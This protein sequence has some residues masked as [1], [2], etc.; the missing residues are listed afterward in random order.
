MHSLS[1]ILIHLTV[2]LALSCGPAENN[3]PAAQQTDSV[4]SASNTQKPAP[5]RTGEKLAYKD[6]TFDIYRSTIPSENLRMY[7]KNDTG[8]KLTSLTSLKK[9]IESKNQE[10]V[11]ATNAGMYTTDNSPKGLYIENGKELV[12]IDLNIKMTNANFYIQPNGVFF[13]TESD[14]KIVT[15]TEFAQYK[16]QAIY[17]TQSGP[18]LVIHGAINSNF[19][20][21]SQ[22]VYI[23]S[24]VGLTGDGNIVFAISNEAV[25]FYDFASLFKEKLQC[26]NALY[27]D[28]AISKMYLPEIGRNELGGS[29]GGMI[30]VVR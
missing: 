26:N 24:G 5:L 20:K 11:F 9:Y 12:P 13:L 1:R 17:A 2:L 29:F 4:K 19:T 6:Y 27:L 22:N 16:G 30:G 3:T 8:E 15:S 14:A 7:W 21:G 10:L 28:G 25:N 18:M 23:R